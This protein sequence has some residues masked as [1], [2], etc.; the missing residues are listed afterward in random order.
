MKSFS[1]PLITL[2]FLLPFYSQAQINDCSE[3]QVVC[4]DSD[5]AFNPMGPGEN[6]F[7]NPNNHPGCITSLEQNSAWYY[8]EIDPTAPPNLV[9]GFIINPFGGYGEDYDWAL[10]GPD[11][12]CGALGFPIRCSSSSFMCGFCPQ[13]G[14]GMGATDVTEG[15]GTGDGFVSTL[16]VQPGQGFYLLID[17]WQGTNNGFQL[18]WSDTA[19]PYLNCAAT[20]PCSLGARAGADFAACEGDDNVQLDGS[21]YG[22]HGNVTYSWSGTNG[23]TG[24]LSDPNTEDPTASIPIGFNG[25]ITYTLTVSEDT[26][27]GTDDVELTVNPLPVIEIDQI[28]P[29][30][31][32]NPPHLLTAVPGGGIWGGAATGNMFNPMISGPGIH[33]VTDSYTDING[34][35]NTASIDIEVYELPDISIDPVPAVFC[36]SEAPVQLTATGSGGAGGYIYMW[37]TPEAVDGNTFDAFFSGLHTVVVTDNNGCTNS[38]ATAVIFYAN[39]DVQIVDPGPICGNLDLIT[40]T[41]SPPGGTFLGSY[42]SAGGV[43]H[44]K[45][46]PPGTYQISYDIVDGHD[47]EGM[48]FQNITI[49]PAPSTSATNNGPLCEGDPIQLIGISDTTGASVVYSWTGPNGYVSNQ[50]NPTNATLGGAYAFHASLGVCSSA[51]DS[52]VVMISPRPD[53]VAQNDGPYC[54]VQTNQLH[55]STTSMD[56]SV[57][58]H[59]TGPNGYQSFLQNPSDTLDPGLYSLV[60]D[61]NGCHSLPATTSV[62]INPFPQPVIAGQ[63]VFCTGFSATLDAG[64]GYTTYIWNDGSV[65]QTLDVT[66]SG[67]YHVTVT[68][69]NGCTGIASS[70][71]T[72]LASLSPL[73]TGTLEFCEGSGTA[74]DAGPGYTSYL[75]S[76]GATSQTI[77][78]TD[79]NNYGVMVTD[80]DG[81]SGS[82]NVN[83]VMHSLPNVMIG[84]STTYCIGGSTILDAGTGYASYLWSDSSTGQTITVSTPGVYSVDVID[85][86]G[87]AGS[88]SAMIDVST[89]L[90][91]V[92]AGNQAF[93]ENGNTTL[94]AGS[95]FASY[96]WSDGSTNQNLFVNVAGDYSVTVS[97]GPGCSGADTV[98]VIE[99]LPPSS[100]LQS[101]ATLCNTQAGGSIINLY[102]LVLSGDVN[103]SWQDLDNSGAAGLFNNLDFKNIAAGDYR[104]LYTTNSAIDPCPEATY[105]VVVTIIDCT[106]PDVF[107]FNAS[108]LCNAGDVLDLSSIENTSEN[109]T[110]SLIQTPAG[111]KPGTLNGT[112]FDATA[113]DPGAY[114]F[115]FSLLSPPPPGCAVDYQV[116]VNVDPTVDAGVAAQPAAYCFNENAVVNLASLINGEDANGTWTETSTSPSQGNA[117][118]PVN[119]TFNTLNQVSGNYTFQYK[120]V[121]PGVCPDDVSAVSV[122]INP[123]P[124]V[125]IANVGQID[126]SHPT[127]SPDAS[128]SSSGTGYDIQWTGPGIVANGN[129]NTL[130][131]TVDQAG[132]YQLTISNT[133]TG[134]SN[135]SSVTVIGN[136]DKPTGAKLNIKGPSCFGDQDAYIHIDQVIGGVAPYQYSLNNG[137]SG[138][139]NAFDHLSAGDYSIAVDDV[140]GCRWDTLITIAAPSEISLD[141]GP[142]IQIVL[143]E[144]ASIQATINLS[145]N[146]IDTL[147]WTPDQLINCFDQA[148]LEGTVHTFN[149][150][151]LK[152]TLVALSGCQVSDEVIIS[153]VKIRK[154]YIPTVFSPN[155][156]GINDIFFISGD[157]GQ[158]VRIK[159]FLIFNRWGDLLHEKIDFQANDQASGWDGR[160]RNE[161]MNPGVYVYVAEV[162][163]IDGI[164]EMLTGDVTLLK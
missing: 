125:A 33:T 134:C 12:T 161:L 137:A 45:N 144:D 107:F 129:E 116:S 1:I 13:T 152:A 133:L 81:C 86:F 80:A 156:D 7:S 65:N 160:F 40:L 106:C 75:W 148:C 8:F 83:T 121:S 26:C 76:T 36:D 142:D 70:D 18:K 143:G 135:S 150:V 53:A 74:L 108:P 105:L 131:P 158:I 69:A 34:C 68:D 112:V 44:P 4:D 141:L 151:T 27:M 48:D 9:L 138:S 120:L 3:A 99:V 24:F 110:W 147:I 32:N 130:H 79:G 23:G 111:I 38:T 25:S 84:G 43:L 155:G 123:L 30:C 37:T 19:A 157:P 90:H 57:V 59:W 15:P 16:V 102:D 82:T 101:T 21:A 47:C 77:S 153:V 98:T 127:Q 104:F 66:S 20:P 62:S 124:V 35:T 78:V 63:H 126:C 22:G 103:G 136:T 14:M 87:C 159:K 64:A 109:G 96:L 2:L 163:Y 17:N 162:E 117:F 113:G 100:Q 60:V 89:S 88:A 46:I 11:V 6:D 67:T 85:P 115:Q 92:I 10:F 91:P 140:N 128:G 51:N 73:I 58:F 145:P 61:V 39:P 54:G 149:T 55:G 114:T 94:N 5:L 41:A 118:N 154:L 71:V 122:V 72:E 164:T 139:L 42:V 56:T 119:G 95:G 146:Q 31:A 49:L 97:N 28:G 50:Q 29:F 132:I 52:T 93:C